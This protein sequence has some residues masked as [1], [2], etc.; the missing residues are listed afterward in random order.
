VT[1]SPS[2]LLAWPALASLAAGIGSLLLVRYL[3]EYRGEAGARL[4]MITLSLGAGFCF[5]YGIGLAVTDLWLREGLEIVALVCLN[6]VGVPFLGFALAYT[7]RSKL[8]RSRTYQLLYVFPVAVTVLLPLNSRHGLF[9]T[10]FRFDPAFGAQTVAYDFGPLLYVAILGGT[11]AAGVGTL[12][13]LD[14]VLSYGPLYRQEALAVA[15]SPVPPSIG[16]ALWLLE[17]GPFVPL[18]TTAPL[19][20]LHVLLDGYAFIG[21]GMFEFSPATN[22]AAER[23]ALDDLRSPVLVLEVGGRIVD[24]N[25]QAERLLGIDRKAVIARSAAEVL[26]DEFTVES[27]TGSGGEQRYTV[28]RDG[29]HLEFRIET[30]PLSDSGDN[31]VGYTVLFQDVTQEVRREER[32]AVLNRVLR[33]NLRNSLQVI[34]HSVEEARERTDDDRIVPVLQRAQSQIT[35]LT[36]LGERAREIEATIA[37][38]DVPTTTVSLPSLLDGLRTDLEAAY[39]DV[40]LDVECEDIELETHADILRSVLREL[41]DNAAKHGSQSGRIALSASI[42]NGDVLVRVSDSGPGIP[43]YELEVLEEGTETGL[44]HGSGLGLWLVRWGTMRLGG[45]VE[46]GQDGTG[47]V[48]TLRLPTTDG[49]PGR[50]GEREDHTSSPSA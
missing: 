12:L 34:K 39:P 15:L 22:R 49:F 7:G 27:L 18:N 41:L 42:R 29:T 36:A 16:L 2:A 47:T 50:D 25:R 19:F 46:F 9:W 43:E 33:H 3:F 37:S 6:W 11:T 26:D 17:L 30:A 24:I 10:D 20:A 13:L 5:A 23:S 28:T 38:D 4:F 32:L 31:H 8:L 45:D 1:L 40:T 14:T 48:V 21:K 44:D 35:D